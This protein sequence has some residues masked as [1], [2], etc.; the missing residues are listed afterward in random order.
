VAVEQYVEPESL[1][2]EELYA[3][4]W[5]SGDVA[6]LMHAGQLALRN[7]FHAWRTQDTTN[8]VVQVAGSLPRVFGVE[9]GKRFGK[10]TCALWIAHELGVWFYEQFRRPAMMRYTSAFQKTIDEIVGSV[11]RVV[12]ETAP[13]SCKPDYHGKRGIRAAGFYWPTQGPTGG[14]V[15]ALA[16]TDK[17]P[18]ALRGQG[19]DFDFLS[20]CAF[21]V[22]LEYA[23][24]NVLYHQYQGRPWARLMAES[25]APKMIATDWQRFILPDARQR[26]AIFT[27]TIE[28]NPRLSR[29]EKDEFISAAGG[30]GNPDCERE[31][32][33]KI[34]GD[35]KLICVPEFDRAIHVRDVELPKHAIC[36]TAADPG[37]VHM[38]GLVHAM[39]DFESGR[40][41]VQK[42]WAESNASSMKVA[43][44][45]AANEYTLWGRWPH[46]RMRTILLDSDNEFQGWRD[47]LLGTEY[48]SIVEDLYGM[49]QTPAEERPDFEAFPGKWSTR[50]IPDHF[51]WW[52]PNTHQYRRNPADRVSDVDRQL[53]ADIDNHYGLEFGGTTKSELRTMV[54]LVRSWI[55][56]GRLLFLP[57]AGPVIDHTEAAQ[58][59]PGVEYK[60][61][62]HPVFSHFDAFSP[63]V[64]LV[65]R[66]ERHENIMPF[67]PPNVTARLQA[68]PGTNLQE[69]LPWQPKSPHELELERR[70][71]GRESGRIKGW[72]D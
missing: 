55:S 1:S 69:G 11:Q 7:Q 14:A 2:L 38:F 50:D 45:C 52:D 39:Y 42:S 43:A 60:L 36:L 3:T 71:T 54:A 41:I 37:Q 61:D 26:G 29:A 24:R 72:N 21:M 49:A 66:M 16:G 44:V 23:L 10:T 6:F 70:L 18:D 12:F 40:L 32:F 65:R 48:E 35:P 46:P 28:D 5:E 19:N 34:V 56:Q 58:R 22:K 47:L 13:A 31:Y 20:E 9:G 33:N 63:L 53:I 51:T 64:Y 4:A 25:S 59:K 17:N 15:L 30:R 27:A 68:A 67:A 8:D 57:G 62:E